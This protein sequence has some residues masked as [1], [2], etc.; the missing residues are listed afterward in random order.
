MSEASERP[1]VD[2]GVVSGVLEAVDGPAVVCDR[3][4][5]IRA[6]NAAFEDRT[7]GDTGVAGVTVERV[8]DWVGEDPVGPVLDGGDETTAP[9]RLPDGRHYGATARPLDS[10]GAVVTFAEDPETDWPVYEAAV[11]SSPDTVCV[12]DTDHRIRLVSDG[13]EAVTKIPVAELTGKPLDCLVDY[14][15]VT[16]RTLDRLTDRVEAVL[17][18]EREEATFVFEPSIDEGT[19]AETRVAPVRHDGSVV[20]AVSLVRDVTDRE[21][22]RE[23]HRE[24]HHQLRTILETLPVALFV[25]DG[26]GR[27]DHVQGFDFDS[28]PCRRS[29][30]VGAP[31]EAFGDQCGDIVTGCR[32]ALD[33]ESGSKTA[34][35]GDRAYETV[36]QPVQSGT[37][38]TGAIAVAM[39]VTEREQRERELAEREQRL[40]A[41]LES[42]ADPIAMQDTDGRYR[43]VN[44]A[45][46]ETTGCPRASLQDAT[47]ADVFRPETARRIEA[48]R[49]DVL[50][51]EAARVVREQLTVR[52]EAGDRTVQL[53][54]APYHGPDDEVRGTVTIARDITELERQRDELATLAAIQELVHESARGVATATTRAEVQRTVCDRLADSA[55]FEA[56]WIGSRDGPTGAVTPDYT[57]GGIAEYRDG[58][59]LTADASDRGQGPGG[60]AYRSGDVQVV[61]DVCGDR[62]SDRS[63]DTALADY[64][65]VAAVPLTHG[66]TTHG[67]LAVYTDRPDPFSERE[68]EGFETLGATVG[69]A[70]SAAQHRRLLES[71][72]VLELEYAVTNPDA[73][74]V[75][76]STEHDCRFVFDDAV[77]ASDGTV[78][79]YLTVDGADPESGAD[80]ADSLPDIASVRRLDGDSHPDFELKWEE[81]VF[82]YLAEAG[83]RGTRVVIEDGV[84]TIYVEAPGD[85]DLRCVTETLE[86]RFDDV[87]LAAKRERDRAD[88]PWWQ[89]HGDIGARLTDRQRGVLQAAYYSGYYEWPRETDAETLAD[90]LDIA[91]TTLLQHLRKGHRRVLEATFES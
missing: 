68:L 40:R 29:D 43:V 16:E 12:V 59:S 66:S 3:G 26:E 30:L 71:D 8:V 90:S 7:A 74:F 73:P 14:G 4:G 18:G 20:G 85:V 69:F 6:H 32:R 77:H 41:V 42:S 79:N 10:G 70:L 57:A 64:E 55:F 28:V 67:I 5:V 27:V 13:F 21:R 88:A 46:V 2:A 76:A 58:I 45:M 49:R 87:T 81:S 47:P 37:S 1:D 50:S 51:T 31:I 53:T 17:Q 33:G 83:A 23:A 15:L 75:A 36:F 24:S 52:D 38:V 78:V 22:A 39:D 54:V 62:T 35:I 48:H 61:D 63:R 72:R 56:A 91:T 9:A 84:A 86:T 65:S 44:E 82:Q 34:T 25:L 80:V 89:A 19:V 11:D 60:T